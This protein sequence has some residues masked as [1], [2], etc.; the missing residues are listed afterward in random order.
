MKKYVI[1]RLLL[2][3]P[4]L[5]GITF[6]S[7]ALMRIAGSDA[8][9]QQSEVSGVALSPEVIAARRA[10]LGLDQPFWRSI[11]AG[12]EDFLQEIWAPAIFPAAVFSVFVSKLPATLLLTVLSMGLTVVIS[13]PLGILAAVRQNRFTDYLIRV[14]SFIGSSLPNF[15][16]AL[17]LMYLLAIYFPFFR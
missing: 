13:L 3:I 7:F 12:W 9:L 6:L 16:V 14:C 15:F 11:S 4:I 8:V 1:R 17:V 10:E 5:L 2:L